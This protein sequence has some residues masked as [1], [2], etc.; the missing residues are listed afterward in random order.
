[1]AKKISMGKRSGLHGTRMSMNRYHKKNEHERKKHRG[2]GIPLDTQHHDL[3]FGDETVTVQKSLFEKPNLVNTQPLPDCALCNIYLAAL[4]DPQRGIHGYTKGRFTESNRRLLQRTMV[5]AQRFVMDEKLVEH[6]VAASLE[7]PDYL[8]KAAMRGIPPFETMWIEW[9]ER[10]K[11]NTLRGLYAKKYPDK[12]IDPTTDAPHQ[13]GYLIQRVNGHFLYSAVTEFES[14]G[15]VKSWMNGTSFYFSNH[16]PLTYDWA[17]SPELDNE[18][19][20]ESEYDWMM[21]NF[22]AT[23]ELLFPDYIKEHGKDHP[24]FDWLAR[25]TMIS[26]SAAMNISDEHYRRGWARNE[27]AQKNPQ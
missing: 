20:Y 2:K 12:I 22:G 18:I 17:N 26:Q 8:V 14:N 25:R 9:P 24:A 6:V 11:V 16:E 7:N 13:L 10:H 4:A 19:G 21:N 1:M 15:K 5:D 3:S 23:T 27:M